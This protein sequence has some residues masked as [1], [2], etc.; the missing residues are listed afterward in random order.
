[1]Q[2][3]PLLEFQHMVLAFFLGVGFFILAYLAWG[4]YLPHP[5][6]RREREPDKPPE[7]E[8]AGGHKDEKNPVAPVLILIYAAVVVWMLAYMFFFGIRGGAIG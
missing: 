7:E 8:I 6:E 5:K 2:F 3:F 1:M 4:T